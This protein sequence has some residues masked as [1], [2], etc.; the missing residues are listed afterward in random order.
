MGRGGEGLILPWGPAG[1]GER[2]RERER[3]RGSCRFVSFREEGL[4]I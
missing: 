1:W 4:S 3:E 2:E